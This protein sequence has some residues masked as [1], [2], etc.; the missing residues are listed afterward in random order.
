MK[1]IDHVNIVVADMNCM[2]DFYTRVLGLKQSKRVT[3]SGSWI[4]R[5]VGL[6]GVRADVVYL[7]FPVGPR[8]ELIQY[9]EPP[10]LRAAGQGMSNT[11]GL[12]HL[13]FKLNDIETAARRLREAGVEFFS[14]IQLVPDEQVTYAGGARKY[15]VYFHDPEGNLLEL[16]EYR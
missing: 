9:L 13:A 12:R 14:E 16:C 1:S 4:D 6:S 5:T 10:G 15:L 3:I 7:E 8:I 11:I 2:F